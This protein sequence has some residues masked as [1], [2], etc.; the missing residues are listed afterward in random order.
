MGKHCTPA[1]GEMSSNNAVSVPVLDWS[2][3]PKGDLHSSVSSILASSL[4]V[5]AMNPSEL[6]AAEAWVNDEHRLMR[7]HSNP[8][9]FDYAKAS[10]KE[11]NISCYV[12]QH[13]LLFSAI[14]KGAIYMI[15]CVLTCVP[16]VISRQT[17]PLRGCFFHKKF[18]ATAKSYRSTRSII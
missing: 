12:D 13:V 10:S 6:D 1:A 17:S 15:L 3:V 11:G 2:K 7:H 18:T 5:R 9:C 8:R 16:R 14:F 4:L